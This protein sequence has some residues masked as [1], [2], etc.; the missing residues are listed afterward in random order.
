V[1][2][3]PRATYR[4]SVHGLIR[5]ALG[6]VARSQF[7]YRMQLGVDETGGRDW[8]RVTDWIE[9]PWDEQ[10]FDAAEFTY[11][12]YEQSLEAVGPRLTIFIRAWHKWADPARADYAIDGVSL[13]GPTPGAAP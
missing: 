2:V 12:S 3:V 7:G 8:R 5:S 9:L 6:D 13:V 4:L 10:P 1:D 11:G